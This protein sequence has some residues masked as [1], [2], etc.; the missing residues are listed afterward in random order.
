MRRSRST[1]KTAMKCVHCLEIGKEETKDH[2][3]PASWY[4]NT[5]PASV[6]RW[7]VPSCPRCNGTFGLLEK[8][9]FIR[10]AI[11]VDPSKAGASGISGAV[12]RSFGVGVQ[13]LDPKEKACRTALREKVLADTMPM[14]DIGPVPLLPDL[15]P[16]AGFPLDQQRA[17]SIS[18]KLLKE[19]C[20]KILRGCEYKLNN[21]KFIEKPYVLRIYFAHDEKISDVTAF[22]KMAQPTALGP[23]FE[24][25]RVGCPPEDGYAVLYRVIL[26]DTFKIYGSIDVDEGSAPSTA[27]APRG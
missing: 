4:P 8:E 11:C 1:H 12:L 10:L 24:V 13:N 18:E 22:V 19:V 26:W 17:V 25:R 5:T 2:V 6:Q 3:F 21:K 9:L 14:S 20:G 23:G 27:A 15:G 16:H 7:T